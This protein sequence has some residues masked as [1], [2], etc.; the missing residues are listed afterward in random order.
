MRILRLDFEDRY[1]ITI[2]PEHVTWPWLV[3]HAAWCIDGFAVRKRGRAA[4]MRL[5]DC[6]YR[7]EVALF[8]EVLL[9]RTPMPSDR[10][11]GSGVFETC[12]R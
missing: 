12:R 9:R 8:G 7:G 11:V 2:V 3:R 6:G 5:N 10:R 4:F 1:K